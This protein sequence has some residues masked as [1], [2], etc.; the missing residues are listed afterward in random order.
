MAAITLFKAWIP[1]S[2]N[3]WWSRDQRS[4]SHISSSMY[5]VANTIGVKRTQPIILSVDALN[6]MQS[7]YRLKFHSQAT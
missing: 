1:F 6:I 7:E 3:K 4:K 2:A 5:A